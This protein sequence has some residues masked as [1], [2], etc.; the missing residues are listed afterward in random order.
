MDS[1]NPLERIKI[2]SAKYSSI[3][4][5]LNCGLILRSEFKLCNND[6][7]WQACSC[8]Y[9]NHFTLIGD[10]LWEVRLIK[11]KPK[12]PKKK[13]KLSSQLKLQF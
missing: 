5:C 6:E 11:I 2:V 7:G 3:V 9:N 4:R 1:N 12:E 10:F 8:G 13:N